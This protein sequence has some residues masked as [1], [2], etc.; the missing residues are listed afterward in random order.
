MH[1]QGDVLDA[2]GNGFG[3]LMLGLRQKAELGA[4]QCGV[5]NV[6][7]PLHGQ[8]R[9]QTDAER[10]LDR[11][12]VAESA[13]QQELGDLVV[14][15]SPRRAEESVEERSETRTPLR[16]PIGS[17]RARP[18]GLP[19]GNPNSRGAPRSGEASCVAV[20]KEATDAD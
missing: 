20:A 13:G 3:A 14:G 18:E 5:A 7:D 17:R 8:L 6:A 12:V 9:D 19:F 4:P 10:A 2:P 16:A 15:N 1:G 11:Q